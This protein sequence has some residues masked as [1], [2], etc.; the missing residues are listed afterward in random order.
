MASAEKTPQF[1][2][3][4]HRGNIPHMHADFCNETISRLLDCTEMFA[5]DDL[6]YGRAAQ[7]PEGLSLAY[8]NRRPPGFLT[9]HLKQNS[10]LACVPSQPWN[11]Q[12][13]RTLGMA[14]SP[15]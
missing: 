3:L 11:L 12:C 9:V 4:Y 2:K 15:V 10:H 13:H 5:T 7:G 6:P 8:S 1:A 14:L